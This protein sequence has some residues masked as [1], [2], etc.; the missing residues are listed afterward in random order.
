[1][2]EPPTE[3]ERPASSLVYRIYAVRPPLKPLRVIDE[4]AIA[5]VDCRV[6]F[7]VLGASHAVCI[8]GPGT[9]VTELL[10]CL[11]PPDSVPLLAEAPIAGL[12]AERQICAAVPGLV[13]RT[14]LNILPSDTGGL[15]DGDYSREER[16]EAAFPSPAGEETPWTRIGWR[17]SENVLRVET[18][19]TYPEDRRAVRS[20]S[21]FVRE[22]RL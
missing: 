1:M 2:N 19:H 3:P 5:W 12:F 10:A 4:R 17:A 18:V 8:D 11:P 22:E 13:C 14:T 7:Y 6:T 20:N 21:L 9:H 15:L 16:L